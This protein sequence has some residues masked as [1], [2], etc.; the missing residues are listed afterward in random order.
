MIEHIITLTDNDICVLFHHDLTFPWKISVFPSFSPFCD[1]GAED[2]RKLVREVLW[3]SKLLSLSE[4]AT[5]PSRD[6]T[7]VPGKKHYK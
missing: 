3:N 5:E 6:A 1:R 7:D 4:E 2:G